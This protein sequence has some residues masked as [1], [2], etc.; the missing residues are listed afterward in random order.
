LYNLIEDS[1]VKFYEI[2]T[3]CQSLQLKN[4]KLEETFHQLEQVFS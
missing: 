1:V 2:Y 4:I 3:E